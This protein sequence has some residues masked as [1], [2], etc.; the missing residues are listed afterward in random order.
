MGI[1]NIIKGNSADNDITGTK[2]DDLI[3]GKG[4]DDV[5]F[6]D[7]GWDIIRGGKGDDTIFGGVGLDHL[8]GQKGKDVLFGG[9]GA[10]TLKGGKGKDL[11]IG[12]LQSS[13][14][15]TDNL[16][17]N[18]SFEADNVVDHNG[19]WEVFSNGI[20]GWQTDIGTGIEIQVGNTGGIGATD[21]NQ[22]VELDSHNAADTNS[23]MYQDVPV[24]D[25]GQLFLLEFD[26]SAREHGD[27]LAS[28]PIEVYWNGQLIDTVSAAS[29]GWETYSYEV[30][31]EGSDTARLEFRAAGTDD[32]YGGLLDD[33][34]LFAI[35]TNSD[36]ILKGGKGADILFGGFGADTLKGGKGKDTFV[37]D[38][39]S[40]SNSDAWDVI[41]DFKQGKDTIDLT[42]LAIEGIDDFSDVTIT[43]NG[44]DTF[45]TANSAD[46]Q[47]E[48]SGVH[49]LI[50]ADF[51]WG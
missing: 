42:G 20:T 24:H 33:V 46:F 7:Y 23:N 22:K 2:Y 16:I 5:I 48:L 10:D 12:D 30:Y 43:D 9:T 28:S 6:G 51:I 50:D 8:S 37:F 32:S 19:K 18:G 36:D 17:V 15:L 49:A 29:A 3:L 35:S 1:D 13:R 31:A 39:L 25:C 45:V 41:T 4:G 47:I 26:Y 21:G 27:T 11:L 38:L 34:K 40:D 44:T 14:I